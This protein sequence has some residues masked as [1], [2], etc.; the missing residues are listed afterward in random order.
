MTHRK[1]SSLPLLNRKKVPMI[2][3]AAAITLSLIHI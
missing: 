3:V 1:S 2:A